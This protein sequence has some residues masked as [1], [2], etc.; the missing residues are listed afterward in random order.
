MNKQQR[1]KRVL[2]S[3]FLKGWSA[4]SIAMANRE[5]RQKVEFRR[6]LRV[7][8]VKQETY[9]DLYYKPG[10]FSA[11]TIFSSEGRSGPVGLIEPEIDAEFFVVKVEADPECQVYRE[12]PLGSSQEHAKAKR[13]RQWSA[14]SSVAVSAGSVDWGQFDLV[15]GMENAI[16]ARITEQFPSVVWA[17]MLEDHSMPSYG[18][19]LRHKPIGYDC[20]F[21]Q[22]FGPSPRRIYQRKHVIDWPYAFLKHTSVSSL[23][24]VAPSQKLISYDQH[25]DG[26]SIDEICKE[27]GWVCDLR[28][29]GELI[30]TRDFLEHLV[31]SQMYW[32]V[33]P[34]RPLWGNA[35]AEAAA[36][37]C[38]VLSNPSL[39]WNTLVS[40]P[41]T[42]IGSIKRATELSECLLND[43]EY[44]KRL[45]TAQN[46]NVDWFCFNRPISQVAK[47]SEG[48]TRKLSIRD[49][50]QL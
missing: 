15:W 3:Q 33:S 50:I 49:V 22:S 43:S 2:A 1:F 27:K 11:D 24:E 31:R 5:T 45:L 21:N 16:P 44:Y 6:R 39:H 8:F 29:A 9:R 38:L 40:V 12:K 41:E 26:A 23:F 32:A 34:W 17:T 36:A 25:H 19:Y 10:P 18:K 48:I 30:P 37:G 42:R 28:D 4:M 14:L 7:A 20:F 47:L 13:K 35:S 46:E